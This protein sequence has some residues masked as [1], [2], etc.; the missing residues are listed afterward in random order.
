MKDLAAILVCGPSCTGKTFFIRHQLKRSFPNTKI[1]ALNASPDL[2]D[3]P[4]VKPVETFEDLANVREAGVVCDDLIMPTEAQMTCLKKILNVHMHHHRV[5]PVFLAA[6]SVVRNN[7]TQ[8][9]T[10]LTHIVF[11]STRANLASLQSCLRHLGYPMKSQEAFK[12]LFLRPQEGFGYFALD[13]RQGTFEP[14]SLGPSLPH[15]QSLGGKDPTPRSTQRPPGVSQKDLRLSRAAKIVHNAKKILQDHPR[16]ER[17]LVMLELILNVL[18]LQPQA[19]DP[20]TLTLF[21]T[22][23]TLA[24][25]SRVKLNLVDYLLALIDTEKP[26]SSIRKLHRYVSKRL[27]FPAHF[28]ENK[29]LKVSNEVT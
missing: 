6:H 19:I 3:L 12:K 15:P 26:P 27:S 14:Q 11:T 28:V 16:S 4:Q 20:E 1:Y 18:P 10:F 5:T 17:L 2:L 24:E 21:F 8:I 22:W 7:L 25:Q 9:L 29:H 23:K 13:L